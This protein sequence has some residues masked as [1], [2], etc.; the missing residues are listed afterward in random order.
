LQFPDRPPSSRT[1]Y[2]TP[3]YLPPGEHGD[4]TT[5]YASSMPAI[6]GG[7][8]SRVLLLIA[9]AVAMLVI[10]GT[11]IAVA[12]S[13]SASPTGTGHPLRL[14]VLADLP[15]STPP[16]S[17]LELLDKS[18]RAMSGVRTLHY[19]TEA[20]FYGFG[21]VGVGIGVS[22]TDVLSL[23][24]SD[25]VRSP[26]SF[27]LD[28]GVAQIGQYVVI[29]DTTWTRR[30]NSPYWTR[31]KSTELSL[32]AVSPL[33][34]IEYIRYHKPGTARL[35]PDQQQDAASLRHVRF[36]LDTARML[37]EGRE[38]PASI[39]HSKL[40]ADAWIRSDNALLDHMWLAVD[41]GDGRGVILR[42]ALSGYN[43]EVDIKPPD[44]GR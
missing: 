14:P 1:Q 33:V 43:A 13:V 41:A 6:A 16:I 15:T 12:L 17:A 40:D 38:V 9:V 32:G 21:A 5:A 4:D 28:T 8:A 2:Y 27:T 25:D 3:E 20:G 26:D 44:D 34:L 30:D 39:A 7:N 19:R 18:A 24:L 42:T 37:S 35:I 31:H 10:I 22:G 29:S 11:I 23:T 36:E